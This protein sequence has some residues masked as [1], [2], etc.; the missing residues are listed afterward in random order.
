[1][2]SHLKFALMTAALWAAT[3]STAISQTSRDS[4]SGSGG[5]SHAHPAQSN[6]NA[7]P[8]PAADAS[9][10]AVLTQIH[11]TNELEIQ[12][13][14]LAESKGSS[15][16]VR[17]FGKTLSEDHKS[18]DQKVKALATKKGISLGDKPTDPQKA[19]QAKDDESKVA[20]L[21]QLS[22]AEFDRE[23]L[24][25]M[26]AGHQRTIADLEKAKADVSDSDVKKLV[27]E[28]MPT[29]HKHQAKADQASKTVS[30]PDQSK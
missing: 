29:L 12:A 26:A 5:S 22:G 27:D 1:M 30:A 16:E 10:Q 24:E 11:A 7:N 18:A 3:T 8:G 9:P 23:F 25:A 20:H 15:S 19:A 4:G 17:G 2:T 21:K 28:L 14:Q 13:G 6:S